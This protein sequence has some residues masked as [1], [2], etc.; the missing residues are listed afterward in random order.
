VQ[1]LQPGDPLQVIVSGQVIDKFQVAT[2]F[3]AWITSRSI[4]WSR[5]RAATAPRRNTP[6]FRRLMQLSQLILEPAT[7]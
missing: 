5:R 7:R 2:R 1:V 3:T 6:E 4:R